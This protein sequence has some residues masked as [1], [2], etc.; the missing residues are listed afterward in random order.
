MSDNGNGTRQSQLHTRSRASG[1]LKSSR[2]STRT[3][4]SAAATR[5]RAKAEA[6]K[7]KVSY[8]EKEA[9]IMKE[10]VNIE[11]NLHVLR[12]EKE[13]EAASK[14]AAIYEEAAAAEYM[15]G[16][17]LGEFQDLTFEDPTK[18]T[19]D[20]I[21]TQQFEQH[22][23]QELYH[24]TPQQPIQQGKTPSLPSNINGT[25]NSVYRPLKE[26]ENYKPIAEERYAPPHTYKAPYIPNKYP[27][28]TFPTPN[29]A[30]YKRYS[31]PQTADLAQYLVRKE[32][33]TSGLLAFDDR[34]ENYWAWKSSFLAAIKEL[35]LS[36][37]EEL[38]LLD[39][40]GNTTYRDSFTDR[41]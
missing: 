38:Y 8:A 36:D 5:A 9:A 35:N 19:K 7:I 29:R 2:A 4:I 17:P 13:A 27:A 41:D 6:A 33:V 20:Y 28:A 26:E 10:K 32:M 11:A 23:N 24:G 40:A 12:Q 22:A 34:P 30:Q 37:Q 21:E 16:D 1:S 25:Q 31:T 15:E 39:K 14:E 18:R 3:S